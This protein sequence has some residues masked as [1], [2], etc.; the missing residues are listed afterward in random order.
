MTQGV[1]GD[2]AS[3][4]NTATA[5]LLSLESVTLQR[6][7]ED[8]ATPFTV[9]DRLSLSVAPGEFVAITGGR[10]S[11]KTALLRVAAGL[12]PPQRGVVR[13]LGR[14]ITGVS[15]GPRARRA[16]AVGYL[17]KVLRLSEG[18]R[19]VDHL[20]LPLLAERVPL[21]TATARAHEALDRVGAMALA[22][23]SPHDLSAGQRGLVALA[24]ALVRR[25]LLLLADE[26]GAPAEPDERAA[27][28]RMLRTLARETQD[29]GLVVTTRDEIGCAGATRML[30]L[31]D[32]QLSGE[33]SRG[34][35]VPLPARARR[36]KAADEHP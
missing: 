12:E 14:R 24:Q 27:L 22:N 10:R 3:R 5:A 23:T 21:T 33:P 11:G 19:V 29:L 9:L 6:H 36:A 15:G 13:I 28:L 34:R 26:P 25:P 1:M 31:E 7:S 18:K 16:R 30:T 32:G 20:T 17:P 2:T 35:V 8:D 4:Q